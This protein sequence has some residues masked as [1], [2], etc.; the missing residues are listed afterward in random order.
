MTLV[1]K[2]YIKL[3]FIVF[4]WGFTAVLGLLITLPP[5]EMVFYR[6]LLAAIGLYILLKMWKK[7][8]RVSR[9]AFITIFLT[10]TLIA[11]HWIFFFLSA[12]VSTASV[13]LAGMATCSLW[14]SFIEPLF[15][16][17]SIKL[18]EVGLGL[19][20][21]VGLYIIFS[22]EFDHSLGLILAIISAILAA[23]FS[24][25]NGQLT[26]RHNPYVITMYEMAGACISIVIFFPIYL[27]F[28]SD[29]KALVLIPTPMDWVY[30]GILALVCT[31]YAYSV[32]VEIMKNLSAYAVNLTV[33][34]E[35]VYGILLA[36]LVFGEKEQMNFQFYIGTAIILLSVLI[37]PILNKRYKRRALNV[38][39]LR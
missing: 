36:L 20:V 25:I 3:H 39:N 4:L 32:S 33:N 8:M 37:Y 28:F 11:A 30:L 23:I 14:T 9:R 15:N 5:V 6:T 24:V 34:L 10:G 21:L 18:F 2:D 38:D 17:R 12:R 27:Y 16:K 31:V 7:P 1:E 19:L 26:H 22:F 29:S 13:C 35:P